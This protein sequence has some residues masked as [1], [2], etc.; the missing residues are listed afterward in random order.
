MLV[1]SGFFSR[2]KT[3]LKNLDKRIISYTSKLL[4]KNEKQY[5]NIRLSNV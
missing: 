4:K 5:L 2:V 1:I 3:N